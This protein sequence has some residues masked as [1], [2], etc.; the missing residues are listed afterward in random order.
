MKWAHLQEARKK[1]GLTQEKAAKLFN[2]SRVT[3]NNWENG[4]SYPDIP[5]ILEISK[6]YNISLDWLFS[7]NQKNDFTEE[8]KE[9]FKTVA[10]IIGEKIK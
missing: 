9:A 5:T 4:R 7:I 3:I 2:T 1:N 10:K 6:K 8:E